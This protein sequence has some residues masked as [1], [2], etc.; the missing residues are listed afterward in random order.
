[1]QGQEVL[2]GVIWRVGSGRQISIWSDPWLPR[3]VTR[4]PITPRRGNI[5]HRVDELIDPVTESCDVQLLAQT[6]W[7]EDVQVIRSL[8]V[9][10]EMDDVVGWHYDSKGRFS[11]KSAYKVHRASEERRMQ[12]ARPGAAEGSGGKDDLWQKLWK[13]DCPPK[14]RH[15]SV[16]TRTQYAGAEED[17]TAMGHEN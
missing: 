1:M 16:A 10:T 8:P 5:L 13:V 2:K 11:V 12:K 17:L 3:D 9:H 7:E 6:F 15:F 14:I 4:R